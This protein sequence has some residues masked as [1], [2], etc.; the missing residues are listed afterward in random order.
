MGGQIGGDTGSMSEL[1]SCLV[2]RAGDL[3]GPV[4]GTESSAP[5]LDALSAYGVDSGSLVSSTSALFGNGGPQQLL[6]D[7]LG[8]AAWV[9]YCK[10]LLIDAD[11]SGSASANGLDKTKVNSDLAK[12]KSDL[13]G[14]MARAMDKK[15]KLARKGKRGVTGYKHGKRSAGRKQANALNRN[16]RVWATTRHEHNHEFGNEHNKGGGHAGHKGDH[17]NSEE[18]RT[19][20]LLSNTAKGASVTAVSAKAGWNGAVWSKK[21]QAKGS[22]VLG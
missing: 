13:Q 7:L 6:D 9:D 8:D 22:S 20:K 5:Q 11:G 4:A 1:V 18:S 14:R 17:K 10:Y 12:W 19:H 21:V 16:N 3:S 15:D 2:G